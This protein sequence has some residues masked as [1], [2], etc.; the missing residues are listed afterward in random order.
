MSRTLYMKF[1]QSYKYM[2]SLYKAR[3]LMANQIKSKIW[4]DEIKKIII[5]MDGEKKQQ[6]SVDIG[7]FTYL[8]MYLTNI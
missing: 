7:S 1:T 2:S 4:P 3:Q 6:I 5:V 8:K